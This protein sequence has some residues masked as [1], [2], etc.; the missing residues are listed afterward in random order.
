MSSIAVR[1]ALILLRYI[2]DHED[3]LSIREASRDLGYSP[4]MVQNIINAMHDQGFVVQDKQTGCYLLG[5]E[6][7]KFGLAALDQLELRKVARPYMEDL[8]AKTGETV[9]LAI[10]QGD[11]AIYIDKVVSDHELRMDAPVGAHRPYN[12][13]AVGKV[14]LQ[15][16]SDEEIEELARK[17]AFEAKTENSLTDA[18]ALKAEIGKIREQGWARDNE[19]F[20][21]GAGCI[22]APIYNHEGNLIAALTVS[23]PARRIS[24]HFDDLLVETKASAQSVS[25]AMGYPESVLD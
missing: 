21:Q 16:F 23:G 14:L 5:P 3:G 10:A 4:T 15:N 9:F 8:S 13:T 24:E 18:A 12:C 20:H 11:K 19:E 6:A 22:S 25:Q 1:R 2:V 17:G 7:I